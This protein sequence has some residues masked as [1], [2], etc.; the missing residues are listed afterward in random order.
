MTTSLHKS[1]I[2]LG[3]IFLSASLAS[4]L[5]A[6][7]ADS[8]CSARRDNLAAVRTGVGTSFVAGNGYLWH[9]FKKAWWSGEK[10]PHLFFHADWDQGFR[11]QDKFGHMLGGYHLTRVGHDALKYACVSEKKSELLSAAFAEFFQLQI[12]V[13]DGH[14]KK[15]GF[16][17]ADVLANTTGMLIAVAQERHPQLAAIKPTMS[18]HKTAALKNSYRFD[19][20]LR[21]SLDYSGQTYWFSTDVHALL[22][23]D[24]KQYWPE[25][26]RLSVGHSVTDWISAEDGHSFR[27]KRRILLSLDLD[28]EKLP[29]E[30]HLWKQIKHQL[31]YYHF[32]APA[33][34]LTPSW[35]G[36]AWYR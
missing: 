24:K 26:V 1:R 16:S 4:T 27:G 31:S 3:A 6:Q 34:Q 22:P 33:L 18:Y 15:Y 19:T 14:Y 12:E 30:N 28:P 36:I 5:H 21:P 9:Y 35:N 13:F 8:T 23:D 17:Y 10:A 25:A 2:L 7:S 32:P 11:D 29:G 20:E